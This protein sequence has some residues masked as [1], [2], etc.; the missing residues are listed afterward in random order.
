[1]IRSMILPDSRLIET[2]F[3]NIKYNIN[4]IPMNPF[5]MN[6]LSEIFTFCKIFF[7]TASTLAT[8]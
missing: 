7:L 2:S 6:D 5:R 3:C 8:H 1:M 4:E